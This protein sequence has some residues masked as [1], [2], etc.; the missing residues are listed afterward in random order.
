MHVSSDEESISE[1]SDDEES[2]EG[3][4][5]EESGEGSDDEGSGNE[6]SSIEVWRRRAWGAQWM[7]KL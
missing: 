6:V 4:D 1:G 2:D 3:S 5:D 7:K